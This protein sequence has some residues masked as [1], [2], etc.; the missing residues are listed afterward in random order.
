MKRTV[1]TV[2][3]CVGVDRPV[4]GA[5]PPGEPVG[6]ATRQSAGE[7]CGRARIQVCARDIE[8][9]RVSSVGARSTGLVVT[10]S[11]H[12]EAW[13]L[14]HTSDVATLLIRLTAHDQLGGLAVSA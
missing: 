9:I 13:L 6:D 12:G 10:T 3:L 7:D 2:A 1:L 14:L 5:G 8:R 11:E 4:Q